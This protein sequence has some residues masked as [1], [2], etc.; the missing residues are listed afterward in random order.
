MAHTQ[1]ALN[2][3]GAFR[4][5]GRG[6]SGAH[7]HADVAIAHKADACA[8]DLALSSVMTLVCTIG[9]TNASQNGVVC[10]TRDGTSSP[11][12]RRGSPPP[13]EGSAVEA[14]CLPACPR[15]GGSRAAQAAHRRLTGVTGGSQASQA[16]Q[17][18]H[19][20][21][22]RLR[23]LTGVTGGSPNFSEEAPGFSRGEESE[24]MRCAGSQHNV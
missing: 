14:R 5:E 18:A 19:R 2:P 23:R 12:F 3:A 22:R 24:T 17:A 4:S 8:P 11:A 1:G 15:S 10:V 21:H 7:T 6:W 20:R 16:A 13:P 9:L